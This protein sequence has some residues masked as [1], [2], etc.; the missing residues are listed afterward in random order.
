MA[1]EEAVNESQPNGETVLD[2]K[3]A[4]MTVDDGSAAAA[5]VG[6]IKELSSSSQTQS[7]KDQSDVPQEAQHS[8]PEPSGTQKTIFPHPRP[9][10]TPSPQGSLGPDQ[11]KKYDELLATVSAWTEV[12]ST[13]ARNASK[14]PITDDDRLWLTRECLLR[15]LRATKWT[16]A[17]AAGKRLMET[18]TW[19]REYGLA[20]FTPEYISPENETGKQVILGFDKNGRPCLYLNPNR[21][22]T[23][24]SDRQLHHLVFMLER[25][26]DLM[27]PEQEMVAL[28]INF[29][30]T[31]SGQSVSVGQG[32]EVLKILQGHYP[33][34][35]G[36][37]LISELPWYITT[38][39]KLISP[40]IDPVTKEKMRFN[41]ALIDHVPKEQLIVSFG[42][43][44]NFEYD[45][46]IYWPT[47][48]ELCDHRKKQFRERWESAGKKLGESESYLRGGPAT[49]TQ[50][51]AGN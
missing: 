1:T 25:C 40:F 15:Y 38:F 44:V 28:V 26:I 20:R 17:A 27:P 24:R 2:K 39:F 32:R 22:N 21:Q 19:R 33:E 46:E 3:V 30:D 35:L 8:A 12:P 11:Q 49:P 10:C 6:N 42:G 4:A 18:L 7:A 31:S 41:E 48:N 16:S 13:S 14:E 29:R 36:R 9:D 37:A 5:P 51:T 23:T 34:R 47:L 43:D 45:H 50:P